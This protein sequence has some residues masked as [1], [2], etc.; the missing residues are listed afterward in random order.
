MVHL[1]DVGQL[2]AHSGLFGDSVKL[3]AR[4]VY[5]LRRMYHGHRNLLG[6][7]GGTFM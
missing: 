5:G 7:P 4:Y 3:G 6:T 2:E 1:G